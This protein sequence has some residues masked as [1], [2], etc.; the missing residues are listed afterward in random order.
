MSFM[1]SQTGDASRQARGLRTNELLLASVALPILEALQSAAAWASFE[2][3]AEHQASNSTTD[4]RQTVSDTV[5]FAALDT[6]LNWT[7]APDDLRWLDGPDTGHAQ[8][9]GSM[10]AQA[11]TVDANLFFLQ[12]AQATVEENAKTSAPALSGGQPLTVVTAKDGLN[13]VSDSPGEILSSLATA[14]AVNLA[15]QAGTAPGDAVNQI[16]GAVN[17]LLPAAAIGN[18]IGDVGAIAFDGAASLIDD[19]GNAADDLLSIV[20]VDVG[21]P[22]VQISDQSEFASLLPADIVSTERTDILNWLDESLN[23]DAIVLP[24]DAL[25][26]IQA[27]NELAPQDDD[28]LAGDIATFDLMPDINLD[29]LPLAPQPNADSPLPDIPI[30]DAP[31]VDIPLTI[32]ISDLHLFG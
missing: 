26:E 30:L 18:A 20:V 6:P 16:T 28:L 7:Q 5:A 1:T 15:G 24:L 17:Q 31:I 3:A 9:S 22:I 13:V 29:S 19:S 2:P 4:S 14:P 11:D 12:S 32:P 21:G 27:A 10:V 25:P 23:D 8:Q